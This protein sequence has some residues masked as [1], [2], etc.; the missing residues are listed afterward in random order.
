[1]PEQY[2]LVSEFAKAVGIS[3]QAVHKAMF[4]SKRIKKKKRLGPV[5]L[6]HSSELQKFKKARS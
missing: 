6:I 3:V 2:I 5:W 1:M 4:D